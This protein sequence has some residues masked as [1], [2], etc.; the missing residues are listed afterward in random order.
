MP[1]LTFLFSGAY[2][3]VPG[4]TLKD[5]LAN[6]NTIWIASLLKV[7]N[8]TT[9]DRLRVATIF[10]PQD[11]VAINPAAAL[12]T[13]ASGKKFRLMGY[14]LT[15]SVAGNILLKDGAAGTVIAV[16]PSGAGGSGVFVSLG[17]GKLSATA[18]NV[19]E[20]LGPAA[21]TASGIVF[22]TEE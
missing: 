18:N 16:V 12:W 21:S 11:A 17:N 7:Y 9:W 22:G 4:D 6:P 10:K 2:P 8:G 15:A 20:A 14:H 13:P 19:L 3:E 1:P 5:A